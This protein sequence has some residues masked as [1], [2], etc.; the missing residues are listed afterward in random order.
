MAAA[1]AP[2]GPGRELGGGELKAGFFAGP[3]GGLFPGFDAIVDRRWR[4]WWVVELNH[5]V[6]DDLLVNGG[7]VYCRSGC[8][9]MD[10]SSKEGTRRV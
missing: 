5:F 6:V 10:N 8:K 7:N 4:F 9:A 2:K 1:L 3:G